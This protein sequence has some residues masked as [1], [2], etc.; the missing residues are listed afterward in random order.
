LTP[1]FIE[2][3]DKIITVTVEGLRIT[4]ADVSVP[5]NKPDTLVKLTTNTNFGVSFFVTGGADKNKFSISSDGDEEVLFFRSTDFEAREDHTYSVEVTARR[6]D[7]GE[8]TTKTITVTVTD[9]VDDEAPTNIQIT[10]VTISDGFTTGG[11][12][13]V[14]VLTLDDYKTNAV[15]GK[16]KLTSLSIFILSMKLRPIFRS[17]MLI[18]P[19]AIPQSPR[20]VPLV[21]RIKIL[22]LVSLFLP[23]T[24]LVL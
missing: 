20:L 17:P 21:L 5:E 15:G 10:N 2:T 1:E 18:L 16:N 11:H 3:A 13:F 19:Q 8:T 9:I 6:K 22:R 23:P 24:A 4:T 14:P 7:T 12:E